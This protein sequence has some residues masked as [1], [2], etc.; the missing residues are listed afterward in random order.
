[1]NEPVLS[2]AGIQRRFVQGQAVLDVLQ[3]IDLVLPGATI[4]RQP[5]SR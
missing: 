5:F 2:L 4:G 3:G 1:M